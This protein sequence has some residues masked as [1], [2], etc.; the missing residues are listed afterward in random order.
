[1]STVQTIMGVSSACANSVNGNLGSFACPFKFQLPDGVILVTKGYKIPAATDI[2]SS[3][4]LGKVQDGTFTPILDAFN[5][6]PMDEDDVI[7]T[8]NTG[9]N[10]LARQGLSS[11][12]FT[13]KK[14]IN[15]EKALENLLSFGYFD[16]MIVDKS[17]NLLGVDKSGDFGGFNAGLVLPKGKTWNDGSSSEGKALEIQLTQ[18]GE[19]KNTTWIEAGNLPMF[20]PTELDGKNEVL[21]TFADANGPVV[22]AS[23]ETSLLIKVTASDGT[24]PVTGLATGQIRSV[25]KAVSAVTDDGS[26]FYTLTIAALT[27]ETLDV[28][29]YDVAESQDSVIV[30]DILFTGSTS[31]VIA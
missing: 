9:V 13:Y 7:E 23:G 2:T 12:K 5:F 21:I 22:P 19:R 18:P 24:T 4:L 3:F 27:A 1:M 28:E 16:V 30:N 26:G 6:E 11:L 29:L 10:S 20:L 15:H 14:G 17:G 25:A 31:V 8:S